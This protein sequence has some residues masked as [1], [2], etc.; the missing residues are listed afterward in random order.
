MNRIRPTLSFLACA[1]SLMLPVMSRAQDGA[2]A[3]AG[4]TSRTVA[5]A[6][7][8]NAGGRVEPAAATE[9]SYLTE[10]LVARDSVVRRWTDRGDAPIRVW[11]QGAAPID[12]WDASFPQMATEA[13]Q[14]WSGVGL[15]VRFAMVSDSAA[16]ELHILWAERLG[17]DESGRT[18]WWSTRSGAITRARVSLST[19]ASDGVAQTPRALRAVALHEIGHALGLGHTNDPSNIMAPWVE[20]AELSG[21]DRS[22]ALQLYQL[23]VG[24][25]SA[26]ETRADASAMQRGRP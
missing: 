21:A 2:A 13:L 5:T 16:A 20:V 25:L 19:H 24:R 8:I 22:T 23:P 9:P 3:F 26:T 6:S 18:V 4:R 1:V 11:I 17:Q 10:L 15:P 12:G 7:V 14:V